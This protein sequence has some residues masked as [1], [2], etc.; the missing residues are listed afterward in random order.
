MTAGAA[1]HG[2]DLDPI[3]AALGVDPTQLLDLS[4]SLNP[5]APPVAPIV[6]RNLDAIHRYPDDRRA[7][8]ALAEA[9]GVDPARLVLTNGGAEAIALVA[10]LHPRGWADATDFS[11]Y[12]RHLADVDPTAP[13]WMSDPNNPTGRLA[14]PSEKAF[15]RDEAFYA[16][17]VGTWTRGDA[18]TIVV[19]SLTKLFACP[20]L[21]LGYV[22]APD[23]ATAATLGERRPRW[24]VGG[25]AAAV[26]PDLLAAADLP[27]W[28]RGIADLRRDLVDLLRRH[29]W[30]PTDD[31]AANYVW[32][33]KAPGLRQRLLDAHIVVRDGA[34]FGHAD[35]VRIAVPGP[36][37]MARLDR[38]LTNGEDQ[39]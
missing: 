32:L 10:E 18:D 29:G 8:A 4:V 15:V 22:L 17:A 30:Q 7:H 13:R 39:R 36:D 35:A 2:G 14:D 23:D 9:M 11:L 21:R 3:A 20:G 28:Q 31:A 16:L 24:S 27:R 25:L 1:P 38:A 34:S 19:G 6:T 26:V 12:R 5:L 37:E 33:P